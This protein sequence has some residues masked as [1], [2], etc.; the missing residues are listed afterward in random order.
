MVRCGHGGLPLFHGERSTS[1][2]HCAALKYA[3]QSA[4]EEFQQR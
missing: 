4:A 1:E 2:G 3:G